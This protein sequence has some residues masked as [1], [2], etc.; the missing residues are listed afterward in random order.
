MKLFF[1]I[2][3]FTFSIFAQDVKSPEWE[4]YTT[5]D[6]SI[7]SKSHKYTIPQLKKLFNSKDKKLLFTAKKSFAENS[8][9]FKFKLEALSEF[10]KE[11][12]KAKN[13]EGAFFNCIKLKLEFEK[14]PAD[15]IAELDVLIH[16]NDQ[17]SRAILYSLCLG[18]LTVES[19]PKLSDKCYNYA[20][21]N[22]QALSDSVK[23]ELEELGITLNLIKSKFKKKQTSNRTEDDLFNKII[24]LVKSK[25]WDG[26]KQQSSNFR[27]KFKTSDKLTDIHA[28][29]CL[30][31]VTLGKYKE[32]KDLIKKYDLKSE[33]KYTALVY[34]A[35]GD[36]EFEY[37]I[38]FRLAKKNFLLSV[39][40]PIL[41]D[42]NLLSDCYFKLGI[43]EHKLKN[44]DSAIKYYSKEIAI[45]PS[46]GS[47][48]NHSKF[49]LELAQDKKSPLINE[50]KLR[51]NKKV[52]NLLFVSSAYLESRKF[53]KAKAILLSIKAQKYGKPTKEQMACT[54][55]ELAEMY[56]MKGHSEE[57]V[58]LLK[59]F[60]KEYLKTSYA[61]RALLNL[62][63]VYAATSNKASFET[64]D[65]IIDEFPNTEEAENAMY[66]KGF[67]LK[68][69]GRKQ[70]AIKTFQT[71]L[72]K[73]P[74]STKAKFAKI[75]LEKLE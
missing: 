24:S 23:S 19:D 25:S 65:L 46:T 1:I 15:T 40:N 50:N 71:F 61:A 26:V 4:R 20:Q 43:L 54:V 73:F 27:K 30:T 18:D 57:S 66:F 34:L 60:K 59:L 41:K 36:L 9:K 49:L 3:L 67:C 74:K 47:F 22:F 12:I 52:E 58:A 16:Q 51:G 42:L 37:N 69:A 13:L 14:K 2:I 29:E 64:F 28:I 53:Y 11:E 39:E 55:M 56:R 5:I 17:T 7:N 68:V 33:S 31:L 63:R 45:S 8:F 75:Y 32:A 44:Y 6:S 21:A 62:A 10:L 48:P 72:K 35:K 70:E 38:D